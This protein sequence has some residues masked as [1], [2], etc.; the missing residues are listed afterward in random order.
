MTHVRRARKGLWRSVLLA[1]LVVFVGAAT[2][3]G[4]R[5]QEG[6]GARRSHVVSP[7]TQAPIE[8]VARATTGRV[9]LEW[10]AVSGAAEYR[11]FRGIGGVWNPQPIA[12]LSRRHFRDLDLTNGVLHSYR[13]AAA[14]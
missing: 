9:D 11:I 4:A 5:G 1:G 2:T 3:A 14:N 13:I 6:N 8:V 12:T 10:S 7:P